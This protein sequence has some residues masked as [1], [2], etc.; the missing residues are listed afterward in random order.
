MSDPQWGKRGQDGPPDLDEIFR[1]L[2]ARLAGL[3]GGN[4]GGG[5]GNSP[6]GGAM[7][8]GVGLVAGIVALLWLASGFYQLDVR[9]QGVVLRFGKFER[10][11][12]EGLN[13]RLPYPIESHEVVNLTQVRSVEIGSDGSGKQDES[14][15]LTQD[16]NIVQMRLSVQYTVKDPKAFV[17]NNLFTDDEAQSSVKQAAEAAIREVVGR[18]KVDAVLNVGRERMATDV[19]ATLQDILDRYK[20]GINVTQVNIS[21]VQPP[22]PVQAAFA[23]TVKAGQDREKQKS[24]GE[25]YYNDVVPRARGTAARL[26]AEADAYKQKS[27]AIAQG[28]A[29]RFSQ[30][31][32][33]YQKAPAVTRQ[34]MY[35]DAMQQMLSNSSKVL[36]DQKNGNSLLYLPL[37]KLIQ[38]SASAAPSVATEA[39]RAPAAPAP[40]LD[41][42][43]E[44]LFGTA[45]EGR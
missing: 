38:Q 15:M 19:K 34:R 23:D 24:E 28:D 17:F 14:L 11:T 30:I 41:S 32:A 45:R 3:F 9:E 5:G 18:T 33:E 7:F 12:Q 21:N 20:T 31:L 29:A 13:W 42:G 1:K 36:V 25:A 39:P 27:V 10:I 16:Q 2:N 40:T 37:D 26:M 8:G 35:L 44:P 6:S 4:K 22:E 43:R